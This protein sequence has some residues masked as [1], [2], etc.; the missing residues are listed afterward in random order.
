VKGPVARKIILKSWQ[1]EAESSTL[2]KTV[3]GCQM[4]EISG[5]FNRTYDPHSIFCAFDD[6]FGFT[7]NA[8]SQQFLESGISFT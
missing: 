1:V 7:L 6:E 2:E 5:T 8:I 4:C 3:K